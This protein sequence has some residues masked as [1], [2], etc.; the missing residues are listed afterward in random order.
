MTQSFAAL[1]ATLTLV[2]LFLLGIA[3]VLLLQ[4][5]LLIPVYGTGVAGVINL[6]LMMVTGML[7]TVLGIGAVLAIL[8]PLKNASIVTMLI[9]A[10]FS[11]FTADVIVLAKGMNLSMWLMI[12]EMVYLVVV[13]V[14]MVRFFPTQLKFKSMEETAE[15]LAKELKTKMKEGKKASFT[16]PSFGKKTS[17]NEAVEIK[18][19]K[20]REEK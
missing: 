14:L 11:M 2:A 16:L 12:P 4:P 9:I 6:H 18:D 8:R 20:E 7:F 5:T 10:H 1:R 13:C 15:Q 3:Y 19:K 17:A